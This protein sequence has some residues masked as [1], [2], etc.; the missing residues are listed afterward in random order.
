MN[1]QALSAQIRSATDNV[2]DIQK[3]RI[4]TGNR[5]TQIFLRSMGVEPGTK[6]D[7]GDEEAVGILKAV[8]AE[9]ARITDC[10]VNDFQ[11]K[12]RITKA[13]NKLDNELNYIRDEQLYRLVRIYINQTVLEA[14][15]TKVVKSYVESH[16]MWDAF[17]ADVKGCGP[18]MAAVCLGYFN[19]FVARHASSF[20]K[21]AGLD[22]VYENG[23]SDSVEDGK[24]VG[25]S[26]RHTELQ[27][28]TDREGNEK[29]KRG[30]TYNP[31]VKTKLMG[32]LAS[33]FIKCPG[34]KYEQIYRGYRNRLDNNDKYTDYTAA[35]KHNMSMRYA[36]KQFLRDMWVAWRT[37][38]G[39]EVTVPYE[40]QYLGKKPHGYNDAAKTEI[41]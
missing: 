41:F 7:T 10:F 29:E 24:H 9:Y 35:H 18:L 33:G 22:V 8:S 19:P 27:T 14:E 39:L 40:V 26:R 32:V 25:R 30:L 4:A 36:V 6:M 34:S 13:I 1:N 21:Y 38:E 37:V 28:Y 23:N 16:P 11:S 31:F 17:F 2:Y 3:L 15:A 5:I 20:W 12:G